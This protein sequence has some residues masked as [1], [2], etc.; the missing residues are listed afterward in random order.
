MTPPL[1]RLITPIADFTSP[2][3]S[4]YFA[5]LETLTNSLREDVKEATPEQLEWQPAPGMNTAG[6]LLAHIAVAEAYWASIIGERAFLCEQVLGIGADDD[7]LPCPEG[8]GPP[9]TLKGKAL[10]WY[11]DLLMKA[12][13]S[14][15]AMISPLTTA[16]L[17]REIEVRG[18]RGVRIMNGHWILYHMVEHLG[19]HYG[20][21]NL[22]MHLQRAGVAK[23]AK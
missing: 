21:I 2:E 20:Q 22:L 5:Q 13:A 16:D 4:L 1:V 3:V 6:M 12:R 10:P 14:T 11:F 8:A 9:D 23:L 7:G 18:S 19:G 17:T 15:H